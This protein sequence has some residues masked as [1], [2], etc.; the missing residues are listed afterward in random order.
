MAIKYLFRN[1]P[2]KEEKEEEELQAA[3][4]RTQWEREACPLTGFKKLFPADDHVQT[5]RKLTVRATSMEELIGRVREEMD[6][7]ESWEFVLCK[8]A[9]S[10]VGSSPKAI[11][12]AALFIPV[13]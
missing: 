10:S 8:A 9:G 5:E 1:S 7:P 13:G 6:L 3:V 12:S 4:R 11:S 2:L